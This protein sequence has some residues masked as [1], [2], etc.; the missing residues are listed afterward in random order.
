[1]IKR[2]LYRVTVE[3]TDGKYYDVGAALALSAGR[4]LS[5]G[6][7]VQSTG[8]PVHLSRPQDTHAFSLYYPNFD[9]TKND[10]LEIECARPFRDIT[11]AFTDAK[12]PIQD[13]I[14]F[15]YLDGAFV[16]S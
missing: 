9:D 8:I 3:H 4:V 1:M 6:H 11:F 14:L 15:E 5:M 2:S 7:Y 16:S 12:Y 10:L 13:M